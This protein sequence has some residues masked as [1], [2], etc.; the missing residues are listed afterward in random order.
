MASEDP[1]PALDAACVS[2][3][4]WFVD[5]AA[6][7][8]AALRVSRLWRRC[9]RDA[10]LP[11]WA[12]LDAARFAAVHR[13]VADAGDAEGA[14]PCFCACAVVAVL[15]SGVGSRLRRLDLSG[16]TTCD[17]C[18]ASDEPPQARPRSRSDPPRAGLIC[19]LPLGARVM[20]S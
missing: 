10:A 18:C 11:F 20:L 14:A 5:D 7:L 17:E 13:S 2:R 19:S 8:G 3:V 12:Q 16:A 15:R 6:T 9:G 1:C 4:L